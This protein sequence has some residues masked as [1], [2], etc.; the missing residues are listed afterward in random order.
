MS[1]LRST[2]THGVPLL[3][4][5]GARLHTPLVLPLQFRTILA[6]QP[7]TP[8]IPF[9]VPY[10]VNDWSDTGVVAEVSTFTVNSVNPTWGFPWWTHDNGATWPGTAIGPDFGESG[11]LSHIW[12]N[13]TNLVYK[14]AQKSQ[15]RYYPSGGG[16]GPWPISFGYIL[17]GRYVYIRG[18]S[19]PYP[20]FA[21]SW[22][23]LNGPFVKSGKTGSITAGSN[24][25]IE[26]DALAYVDIDP[27][28][29]AGWY[30]NGFHYVLVLIDTP[31]PEWTAGMATP[32]MA[33]PGMSTADAG[34]STGGEP[35]STD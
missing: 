4:P 17:L 14:T 2:G 32:S 1:I 24:T 9:G 7:A 20:P 26:I 25:I 12:W 15:A 13:T 33:G 23:A 30:C 18:Y 28:P 35:I 29:P 6:T 16:L 31:M 8:T 22:Q 3:S 27:S 21:F 11:W 5:N 10:I 34:L 19:L